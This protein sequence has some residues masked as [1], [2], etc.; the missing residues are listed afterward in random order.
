[1]SRSRY[2]RSDAWLTMAAGVLIAWFCLGGEPRQQKAMTPEQTRVEV[3]KLMGDVWRYE[4][5]PSGRAYLL[6]G[7]SAAECVDV[8]LCELVTKLPV[9]SAQQN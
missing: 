1:M 8:G 6:E 3:Q 9:D 4:T 2:S 7:L 5:S